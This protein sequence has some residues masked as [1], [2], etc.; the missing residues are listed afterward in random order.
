MEYQKIMTD[1]WRDAYI[2]CAEAMLRTDERG[3]KSILDAGK[4]ITQPTLDESATWEEA[5]EISLNKWAEEAKSLGVEAAVAADVLAEW[6]NL[7]Q[8]YMK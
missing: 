6:K 7:R 3:E 2:E 1:S 4:K 5:A 8:K